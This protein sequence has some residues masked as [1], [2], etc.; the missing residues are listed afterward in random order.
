MHRRRFYRR[1]FYRSAVLSPSLC[2]LRPT[3]CLAQNAPPLG[4]LFAE[5]FAL[6]A[7]QCSPPHPPVSLV[8]DAPSSLL[9]LGGPL[10]KLLS[11]PPDKLSRAKRTTTWRPFRRAFRSHCR[12]M[13]PAVP[14][15]LA[16]E[17]CIVAAFTARRSSRRAFVL[18]ARQAVSRKTHHHLAVLSPSLSPSLPHN[19]AR[20]TRRS[21]S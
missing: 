2:P 12:T 4:G 6:I 21:S 15:G 20:R 9:P 1:R 3:S 18:C 7:A 13:Q 16:H 14:A 5:P 17:R 19:A 10:A 8:K 11:S